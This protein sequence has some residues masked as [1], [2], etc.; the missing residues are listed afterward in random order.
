MFFSAVFKKQKTSLHSATGCWEFFDQCFNFLV[1]E[2]LDECIGAP[3]GEQQ[4][5]CTV[6]F[7]SEPKKGIYTLRQ[8]VPRLGTQWELRWYKFMLNLEQLILDLCVLQWITGTKQKQKKY[9]A[10]VFCYNIPLLVSQGLYLSLYS[11]SNITHQIC[12]TEPD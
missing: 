10:R 9:M 7:W 2:I 8:I 6:E 5:R 1:W 4:P 11:S 3:F 12:P